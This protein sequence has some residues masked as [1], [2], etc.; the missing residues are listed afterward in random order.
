[1]SKPFFLD[2]AVA[3]VTGVYYTNHLEKDLLPECN[4]LYPDNSY[5]FMQDGAPS[6]TSKVC[7]KKLME[8]R[9]KKFIK[10]TEWPPNLLTAMLMIIISGTRCR[11][12]CMKGEES[13]L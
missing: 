2:T 11:K 1:M 10:G 7:Q 5:I 6:H 4:R 3:K 12:R 8:K 9:G 13:H